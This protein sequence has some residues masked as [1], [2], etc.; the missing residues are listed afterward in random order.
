MK[1]FSFGILCFKIYILPTFTL[2]KFIAENNMKCAVLVTL[3]LLCSYQLAAVLVC[4]PHWDTQGETLSL[5]GQTNIGTV[6]L[7]KI[8]ELN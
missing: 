6:S 5:Q 7:G 4:G 2:S 1:A 8:L 3:S